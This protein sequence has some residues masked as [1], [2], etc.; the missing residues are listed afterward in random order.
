VEQRF[1][2]HLRGIIDLLSHHL[3]S[4]PAVFVRELLQNATDAIRAR[5]REEPG[6]VGEARITV[7][8]GGEVVFEDDGIGLAEEEIHRF[9]ATIGESSKRDAIAERRSDYIGQFGIGLLSCFMVA[10]EISVRTRSAREGRTF[11]WRGRQDGTYDVREAEEPLPGPGTRVTLRPNAAGEKEC[12]PERVFELAAHYGG[13]LPF[14]IRFRSRHE[15][16]L[17]NPTPPPWL[18]GEPGAFREKRDALLAYGKGLFGQEAVDAIPLRATAGAIEGVAYVLPFAPHFGARQKHRVYLKRMLLTESAETLLPDWAFFVRCVVNADDLRPTASREG[19]YED[20]TLGHARQELGAELRR[21]LVR[22]AREAPSALQR[23]IALHA[24]SMKALALDDDDFFALV[25]RWFVFETSQGTMKLE[26]I[27]RL[28]GPIRYV[29]SLEGFRQLARVAAAQGLCIVNAAYTY[30]TAILEKLGR[31]STETE[32]VAFSANDLPQA[33]EELDVEERR[34]VHP[35][36]HAA[37][38]AIRGYG[39]ELHVKKFLPADLPA[40]YAADDQASFARDLERAK[41]GSDALFAS[42]LGGLAAEA[43]G[44]IPHLYLN[45]HNPV[46]VRLVSVESPALLRTLVEMIYVQA[47]LLAHRPLKSGEMALLNRGLGALIA[48]VGEAPRG[49]LH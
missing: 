42:L 39:C 44:E 29:P 12:A 6:Y 18:G 1:Q 33:F 41:E 24:L 5:Q 21:Y 40:L 20:D 4:S 37:S 8:A 48:A 35:L 34:R 30:D 38:G 45:L 49:M 19:F 36:L 22:L 25:S 11:S 13:M 10:D 46:I 47:L 16:R 2:V 3:Y 9:L 15:E 26:E 43:P 7:G 31:L 14:P 17:V 27:A 23:L 32:V 28:G